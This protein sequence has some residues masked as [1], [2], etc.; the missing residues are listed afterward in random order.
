MCELLRVI[1]KINIREKCI[2]FLLCISRFKN[3]K[4][5]RLKF[6]LKVIFYF[7]VSF[8][9]RQINNIV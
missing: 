6:L 7:L 5:L 9:V 3:C 8:N 2:E 1:K 4:E